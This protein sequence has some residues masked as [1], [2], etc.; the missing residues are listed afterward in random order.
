MNKKPKVVVVIPENVALQDSI[1][2]YFTYAAYPPFSLFSPQIPPI[3]NFSFTP[4][5]LPIFPL[6]SPVFENSPISNNTLI[7]NNLY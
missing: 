4:P 7:F 1:L 3:E 5:F 6:F 2:V